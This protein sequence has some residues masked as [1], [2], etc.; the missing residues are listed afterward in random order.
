[1]LGTLHCVKN[2]THLPAT[3]VLH[4][5]LIEEQPGKGSQMQSRFLSRA[6]MESWFLVFVAM[7]CEHGSLRSPHLLSGFIG[8]LLSQEDE[9][10]FSLARV[11][12]NTVPINLSSVFYHF[13]IS[14]VTTVLHIHDILYSSCL[15]LLSLTFLLA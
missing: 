15:E 5:F 14:A 12:H 7:F 10:S 6:G 13:L 11:L 2:S 4:L 3:A 1:M 9:F 8:C